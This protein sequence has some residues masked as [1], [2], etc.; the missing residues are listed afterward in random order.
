M[1]LP[2]VR[3]L[4]V[5]SPDTLFGLSPNAITFVDP[6]LGCTIDI[7]IAESNAIAEYLI[8]HYDGRTQ[9]GGPAATRGWG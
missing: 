2:Q 8:D 1:I 6:V 9:G 3:T 5:K 4:R 7:S